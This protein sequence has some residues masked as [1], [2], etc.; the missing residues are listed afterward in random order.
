MVRTQAARAQCMRGLLAQSRPAMPPTP[1]PSPPCCHPS[2]RPPT[3]LSPHPLPLPRPAHPLSSPPATPAPSPPCTLARA[4]CLHTA[5]KSTGNQSILLSPQAGSCQLL[6]IGAGAQYAQR[7]HTH[8]RCFGPGE[9]YF[10]NSATWCSFHTVKKSAGIQSILLSPQAGPNK[11]RNQQKQTKNP[12]PL[13]TSFVFQVKTK[14][15]PK[16]ARTV[17]KNRSQEIKFDFVFVWFSL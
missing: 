9:P 5:N 15:N 8:R 13:E 3:P 1:L 14:R 16:I 2:R 11:K 10:F 6:S 4:R 12:K 7:T 17:C